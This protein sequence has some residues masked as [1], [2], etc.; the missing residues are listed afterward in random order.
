MKLPPASALFLSPH[1]DD[2]VF[3]C[4]GLM[5]DLVR[6]GVPVVVA[7]VFTEGDRMLARRRAEDHAAAALLGFTTM[8][9]GHRDAPFREPGYRTF[10]DLLFGSHAEDAMTREAVTTDLRELEPG[11]VFAP[12]GVGTHVDHRLVHEVVREAGWSDDVCFYEDRPYAYARGLTELR[13]AELG[14]SAN[15]AVEKQTLLEDYRQLPFVR[16]YLTPGEETE[17]CER[18][19]LGT[20]ALEASLTATS[21]LVDCDAAACQEAARSYASQYSAFCGDAAEH[22]LLDERHSVH[23]GSQASRCERYWKLH[24]LCS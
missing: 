18:L 13:L 11:R 8:H 15:A 14:V 17:E 10:R 9:L 24:P 20:P 23:C 7:T 21:M 19:L 16:R 1:L 4:A 12:L 22:A 6:Q 2:A 5:L 3:S